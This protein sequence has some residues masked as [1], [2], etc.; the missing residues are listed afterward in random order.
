VKHYW[1]NIFSLVFLESHFYFFLSDKKLVHFKNEYL[2]TGT[3][4]I[5]GLNYI[6]SQWGRHKDLACIL[7][8]KSQCQDER[9]S[10]PG[11]KEANYNR[12]FRSGKLT[13]SI[14]GWETLD[15]C[16]TQKTKQEP[17][18]IKILKKSQC[19]FWFCKNN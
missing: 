14:S 13:Y 9:S 16:T 4:F 8:M 7:V 15:V 10:N 2:F 18:L 12:M 5:P 11:P 3:Y 6:F 19:Y 1:H 17:S